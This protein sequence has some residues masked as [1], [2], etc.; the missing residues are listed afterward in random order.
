MKN[1]KFTKH[2]FTL[3]ELV[4]V[5]IILAVLSTIWFISYT[6]TLLDARNSVR[7]S[8]MADLLVWLKNHK[9]KNGGYPTPWDMYNI[10]NSWTIILMGKMN[11]NVMSQDIMKK[12]TDP[13]LIDNYYTY[14]TTA[15]KLFFQVGMSLE[16]DAFA[17]WMEGYV[18]GDYQQVAEFAPS[19]V[20]ATSTGWT[21]QSMASYFVVNKWTLNL[22]YDVNGQIYQTA[23][24][25]DQVVTEPDIKISKFYGYYSCNE[26]YANWLSMGS[27]TY[28]ILDVSWN[29][30]STW[31][32]MNY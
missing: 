22:M 14:S 30:T 4:V 26:I 18:D 17:S 25:L 23:T 9:F 7:V 21:I 27:G 12:P 1:M 13:L 6:S 24:S 10:T 15:N 29:I 16:N 19:I 20:M 32:S 3:V 28:K 31:C 8:D 5:V 2:A 11:E